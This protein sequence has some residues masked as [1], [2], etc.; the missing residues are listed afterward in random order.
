M[1][2]VSPMPWIKF[3]IPSCLNTGNS[4]INPVTFESA[5]LDIPSTGFFAKCCM[6]ACVTALVMASVA[7]SA[8][9]SVPILCITISL[10][11]AV[12]GPLSR[13][14]NFPEATTVMSRIVS[15]SILKG[16]S[17]CVASGVLSNEMLLINVSIFDFPLRCCKSSVTPVTV[18]VG[19]TTSLSSICNTLNSIFASCMV[20][21]VGVFSL[22]KD[23]GSNPYFF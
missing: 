5:S 12:T 20:S 17:G 16:G 6:M 8:S 2:A 7:T 13:I 4:L 9:P 22:K 14:V 23:S 11:C 18:M 21:N 1:P 19:I 3:P 10:M 15:V